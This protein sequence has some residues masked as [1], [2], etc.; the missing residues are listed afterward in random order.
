VRVA[1]N[2]KDGFALLTYALLAVSAAFLARGV[3]SLSSYELVDLPRP[4]RPARTPTSSATAEVSVAPIL[5][6]N[7][8]DSVTGPLGRAAPSVAVRSAPTK[9][10]N[11]L[12]APSCPTF[13]V[14]STMVSSDAL[15]SSAMV[16]LESEAHARLRRVGDIVADKQLAY[17]GYNRLHRSPAVWFEDPAGLCQ[18]L[19]FSEKKRGAAA[20]P[21]LKPPPPKTRG[22]A[23]PKPL[24]QGIERVSAQEFRL[25]RGTVESIMSQYPKLMRGTRIKP[26]E[27]RG[28][29]V[30]IRLDR[31]APGSLLS[32]LGLQNGD[33]LQTING[34]G[35]TGPEHLLQA[36]ARVRT[37][38][39]L[40]LQIVRGG[41]KL[42]IDYR[43][44]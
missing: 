5:E 40:S 31:V 16:K 18:S 32:Q 9:N 19:V 26:V 43:I 33:Q 24:A 17:I 15:W 36:Y 37:A 3:S 30:G 39:N 7:V 27:E 21:N 34:F 6:R 44:R 29:V 35:L 1:L 41:K 12:S 8:F 13:E 10:I 42:G 2:R 23:L 20:K 11:P 4:P 14:Y 22:S 38:D 25:N 28:R